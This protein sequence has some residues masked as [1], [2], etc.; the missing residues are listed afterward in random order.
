VNNGN[1]DVKISIADIE[2]IALP[3]KPALFGQLLGGG[4]GGYCG[5]VVGRFPDSLFGL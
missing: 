4:V 5:G 3:P 2:L 1:W